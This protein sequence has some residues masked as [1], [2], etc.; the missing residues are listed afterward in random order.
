MK[1][2]GKTSGLALLYFEVVST[3]ALIIGLVLVSFLLPGAATP[4]VAKWANKLAME[5]LHAGLNNETWEEAQE[6][7][8]ILDKKT[9]HMSVSR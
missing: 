1:K 9:E 6:P 8:Q 3:Y 4:V 7:E 2:V 5:R